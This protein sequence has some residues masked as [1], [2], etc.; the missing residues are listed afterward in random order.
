MLV[1]DFEKFNLYPRLYPRF[2]FDAPV[3]GLCKLSVPIRS[4]LTKNSD[5]RLMA[6][7]SPMPRQHLRHEPINGALLRRSAARARSG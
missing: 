3:S 4:Q 1:L 6:T 2:A 7:Q 5:R